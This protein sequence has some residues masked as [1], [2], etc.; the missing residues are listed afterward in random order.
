MRQPRLR[1][2]HLRLPSVRLWATAPTAAGWQGAHLSPGATSQEGAIAA[3]AAPATTNGTARSV[4]IARRPATATAPASSKTATGHV[5]SATGPPRPIPCERVPAAS[6]S[7]VSSGAR[8]ERLDLSG[9]WREGVC[10]Q[11]WR[12]PCP[13]STR[14]SPSASPPPPVPPPPAARPAPSPAF[15]HPAVYWAALWEQQRQRDEAAAVFQLQ[16]GRAL[17]QRLSAPSGM[18]TP[19]R[20]KERSTNMSVC[21]VR[22]VSLCVSLCVGICGF[23]KLLCYDCGQEG[24]TTQNC[25]NTKTCRI[26]RDPAHT[27]RHCPMRTASGSASGGGGGGKANAM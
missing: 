18:S 5:P 1:V 27:A 2:Q 6:A 10:G 21:V 23:Q 14:P 13:W 9:V 16:P 25:P 22:Y 20:A 3:A 26:C 8:R 4:S 19:G 17:E 15:V 12:P 11:E 24:H 7:P